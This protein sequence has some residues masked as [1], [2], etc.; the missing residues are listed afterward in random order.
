MSG[1]LTGLNP[2]KK[3]PGTVPEAVWHETRLETLILAEDDLQSLF[4]G[5][6]RLEKLGA[7]D[8]LSRR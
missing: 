1:P 8:E 5:I 7:F 4:G 2:L 6:A 3:R